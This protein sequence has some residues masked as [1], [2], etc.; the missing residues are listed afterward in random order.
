M[1]EYIAFIDEHKLGAFQITQAAQSFTAYRHRFMQEPIFIDDNEKALEER[2]LTTIIR[3]GIR[4]IPHPKGTFVGQKACARI[5]EKP[6]T[7]RHLPK[8]KSF[9]A[10][11]EIESVY[12]KLISELCSQDFK[13][14]PENIN[15]QDKICKHLKEIYH[16]EFDFNEWISIITFSYKS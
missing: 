9:R 3:P 12:V 2:T 5:L 15:T 10:I 13:K 16:H 14:L 1:Q 8:F 7:S 4:L 11:V 6:G